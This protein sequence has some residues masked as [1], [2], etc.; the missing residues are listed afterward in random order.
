MGKQEIT[1]DPV[2]AQEERNKRFIFTDRALDTLEFR[3]LRAQKKFLVLCLWRFVAT[4]GQQ[5]QT[6]NS[7]LTNFD[8]LNSWFDSAVCP[9]SSSTPAGN[10]FVFFKF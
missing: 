5:R 8:I 1:A 2:G 7:K 3:V 6:E 9:N 4:G 10:V